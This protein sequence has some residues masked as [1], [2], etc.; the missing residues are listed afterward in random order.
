MKTCQ[1]L[2]TMLLIS[3]G[4]V[5]AVAFTPG[6]PQ[7]AEY[8]GVSTNITGFTVTWYLV[9]Y[10]L[11]QLF[12]GPLTNYF[13]SRKT[14][15]IGAIVEIIG[16][17]GCIASAPMHSF[18]ILLISR[19]IMAIGAG[20]GLTLAFILTS[21]LADPDKNARII[22]LL[23]VSFAITPGLAV[24]AGGVLLEYFNWTSSFYLMCIYG[25]LILIIGMT[26]PEVI[27]DKNNNALNPKII[28]INYLAQIK[29]LP[30]VLGGLL[31][32]SGT[33]F[34]YTFAAL[35]PF[36][37][38]DIMHMSTAQYGI[39]NFIPVVGMILGSLM[40]STLGKT[41]STTRMLK[42]GL[43]I[44]SLGVIAIVAGL[45]SFPQNHLSLF[46]PMFVIYIG[47]SF[48]FGNSSALALSKASDKSN[49]SAMLSFVNM[50]S[51]VV[52]VTILGFLN[53]SN[54]LL[55]PILYVIFIIIGIICFNILVR[56]LKSDTI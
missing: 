26:L 10:T 21:K 5:G 15:I 14:I 41:Y 7:I 17:T 56:H 16:A 39:Y 33:C 35:A 38:M 22:S 52:I 31:V 49:A 36:I 37:A 44:A 9:G 46:A 42:I 51:A 11:G 50:G 54:I 47:F 29:S 40:A 1:I 12:Y 28:A 43:T 4:S 53:N 45:G 34:V 13:G 18:S 25:L 8:F 55:L 27:Q 3:F 2:A 24:F 6:L 30:V 48:V 32:G 19:T 23:T 20:S